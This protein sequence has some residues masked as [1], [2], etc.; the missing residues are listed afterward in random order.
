MRVPDATASST[1]RATRSARFLCQH[2]L[3]VGVEQT[4]LLEQA[5]HARARPLRVFDV[6]L[7]RRKRTLERKRPT[8]F[9]V[10]PAVEPNEVKVNV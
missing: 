5:H 8:A 2:T 10:K 3:R 7:P 6:A 9:P 4:A 1:Q